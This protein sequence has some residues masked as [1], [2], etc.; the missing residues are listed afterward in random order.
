[1]TT[2]N[3][4]PD[5]VLL[6][7]FD[8]Y[9]KNFDNTRVWKWHL[10]VHVCQRWRQIVFASPLRLD[11]RILCT[12]RNRVGK[13]LCIWPNLPIVIEYS[14]S[15]RGIRPRKADYVIAA[16]HHLDRV[17][18]VSL[19]IKRSQLG[20]IAT[21]M[22]KPFP[23]LT[24]LQIGSN[25]RNVPV[26]PI[27]F[28]GR[29]A[30]S[31][32][33][34]T[35]SGIP[36]PALPALLLS[37]SNLFALELRGIPPTGYISPQA[38]VTCLAALPRLTTFD[39][40]F[41]SAT[42]L[43]EPPRPPITRIVL[44][45]LTSF[46]FKGAS[47][48][49]ED[50]VSR[51]NGPQ[52]DQILIVYL[53]QFVDFQVSQLS[54]F[55][56]RSVALTPFRHAQVTFSSDRVSFDMC[57]HEYRRTEIHPTSCRPPTRTFISC[58]GIDWQVSHIAQV[59]SQFSA[60]LSDIICL[61]L[62]LPDELPP[63]QVEG[64]DGAEWLLLLHQFSAVQTM[65]ASGK[66]ARL[67]VSTLE[68]IP[69]EMVAD[70]L[71]SLGLIDLKDQPASSIENFVVARRLSGHPVTIVDLEK[72]RE[73]MLL[74]SE[75]DREREW[76]R[77]KLREREWMLAREGMTE[78]EMARERERERE[79][80]RLREGMKERERMG[81]NGMEVERLNEMIREGMRSRVRDR[82]GDSVVEV[83]RLGLMNMG[84]LRL[85]ER[86]SEIERESERLRLMQGL[87]KIER[88]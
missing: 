9:R 81:D 40:Q 83:E 34:I 16:L 24:R 22:K 86:V 82:M 53:N 21:A 11:L 7:I 76:M 67:V 2:I 77:E 18:D 35:L 70:V 74:L 68:D 47:E 54:K 33:S 20:K 14:H 69:Q 75:I 37:A 56:E 10:L 80:V 17:C 32:R 45:A 64:V 41:Q 19:D 4:L 52:L 88:D 1:M 5:N 62:E 28:L 25:D 48:Y 51:I 72:E 59:L 42:P 71:P 12:S 3:I 38:M 87:R 85:S 30:P 23:V 79:R 84:K 26:L 66:L 15:G 57:R 63:A 44:P 65:H 6:E 60:T 50:L 29:S 46:E 36:Y 78:R 8:L 13:N 27:G 73:E 58:R 55:I 61:K 43:P 49:L 31:L 39:I